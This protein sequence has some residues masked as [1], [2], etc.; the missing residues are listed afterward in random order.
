MKR[1]ETED[2]I[3]SSVEKLEEKETE[4]KDI[5]IPFTNKNKRLDLFVHTSGEKMS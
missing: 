2:G 3:T 4:D 1:E 5:S